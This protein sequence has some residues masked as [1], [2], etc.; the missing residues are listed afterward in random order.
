[1]GLGRN[2]CLARI[3]NWN[4]HWQKFYFYQP[5]KRPALESGSQLELTC[6]Y[7]TSQ[8]SEPVLPG[9]GTRNEMCLDTL[10]VVPRQM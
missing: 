7:D 10:M 6:D 3:G 1:M 4:F 8:D 5:T 2:E 9:W